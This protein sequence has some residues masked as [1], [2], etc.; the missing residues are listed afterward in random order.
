MGIAGIGMSGLARWA[1][2]DGLQ[3][4]G[5]DVSASAAVDSL[6]ACGIPV[7]IGHDPSHLDSVSNDTP[8]DTLVC[9]M[10]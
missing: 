7:S 9:S 5:C 4:S 6:Q 10:A 1:Y 3:V 8:V 2:A